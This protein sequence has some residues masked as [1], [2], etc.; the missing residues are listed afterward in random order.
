MGSPWKSNSLRKRLALD[1]SHDISRTVQISCQ[2]IQIT[3]FLGLLLSSFFIKKRSKTGRNSVPFKSLV[4]SIVASIL[5]SAFMIASFFPISIPA[6]SAVGVLWSVTWV[7]SNL[8]AFYM[9]YRIIDCYLARILNGRKGLAWVHN[10]HK[11]FI[12]ILALVAL[13]YIIASIVSAARSSSDDDLKFWEAFNVSSGIAH[14]QAIICIL[15]SLE[16]LAWAIFVAVKSK[17]SNITYRTGSISILVGSIFWLDN[18]VFGSINPF[19]RA[20]AEDVLA[21]ISVFTVIGMIGAYSGL[22]ICC[23]RWHV[24]HP[25]PDQQQNDYDY[26][27]FPQ[28]QQPQPPQQISQYASVAPVEIQSRP[29]H[30]EIDGAYV[31]ELDGG[32]VPEIDGRT[33]YEK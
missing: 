33:R 28:P 16:I 32:A 29:V 7:I 6:S 13:L 21:I 1:V 15:L 20:P 12:G 3:V 19:Q 11:A 18:T 25:A 30:H 22:L 2:A 8:L 31:A 17:V 24:E 26:Q 9:F 5:S 14:S 23:L 27:P 4:C 10:I